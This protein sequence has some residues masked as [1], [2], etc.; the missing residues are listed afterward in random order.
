MEEAR[1]LM[2]VSH[3]RI[4]RLVGVVAS[5]RPMYIVTE[6]APHGCL[7][8][9]LRHSDVFA[10]SDTQTLLNVCTQ[11]CI[12]GVVDNCNITVVVRLSGS[13][14]VSINE[15]TLCQLALGWV[16]SPGFNSQC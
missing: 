2:L 16:I 4:V 5:S 13:T 15:V 8:D 3:R 9:C 7:K 12:P 6:L 14:L 1:C 11:V 10:G